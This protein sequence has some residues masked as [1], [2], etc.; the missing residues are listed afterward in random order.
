MCADNEA[1]DHEEVW[2][3]GFHR[4]ELF[5]GDLAMQL[6]PP[7]AQALTQAKNVVG[8]PQIR[9]QHAFMRRP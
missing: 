4:L 6:D 3:E 8:L 1:L 2:G 7:D 5:Q 9:D